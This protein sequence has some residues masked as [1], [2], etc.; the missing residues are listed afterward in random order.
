MQAY[1][2]EVDFDRTW[3]NGLTDINIVKTNI[4]LVCQFNQ[5]APDFG[6]TNP[7]HNYLFGST[8]NGYNG[9]GIV[10]ASY[11]TWTHANGIEM[12]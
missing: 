4:Y 8:D 3:L 2:F 9:R 12:F 10:F 6:N 7:F 5:W 11:R 1:I